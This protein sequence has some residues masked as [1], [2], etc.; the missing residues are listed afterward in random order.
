[1]S[2]AAACAGVP[3]GSSIKLIGFYTSNGIK[4][5][6]PPATIAFLLLFPLISLALR[7][8]GGKRACACIIIMR[9][10]VSGVRKKRVKRLFQTSLIVYAI[11]P[12]PRDGCFILVTTASFIIITISALLFLS[13]RRR[14]RRRHSPLRAWKKA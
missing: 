4:T 2:N 14:Q 6:P 5:K 13:W 10:L 12:H 11:I 7:G 9:N 3:A 8:G 1:M